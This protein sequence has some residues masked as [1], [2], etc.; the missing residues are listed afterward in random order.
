[1]APFS[2]LEIVM[3]PSQSKVPVENHPSHFRLVQPAEPGSPYKIT[4]IVH[5]GE[6]GIGAISQFVDGI[7]IHTH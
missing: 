4:A 7:V 3:V 5:D 6:V 2:A 1:M